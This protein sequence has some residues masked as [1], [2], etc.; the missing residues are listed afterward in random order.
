MTTV[1]YSVEYFKSENT[2]MRKSPWFVVSSAL[3]TA[4]QDKFVKM[5]GAID[6]IPW[7]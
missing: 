1:L 5:V 3:K 2:S 7:V 6:Q 4:L